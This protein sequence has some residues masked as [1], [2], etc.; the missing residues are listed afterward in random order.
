MTK[1]KSH[2]YRGSRTCGGGTHKNRRGGGSRGGRG[3]AGACKHNTMRA[4]QEGWMFGK[5]GFHRPLAVR[6]Y[7]TS[8]NVGE[9]DELSPYL[10]EAG[11][12]T[13]ENGAVTIDLGK[14]GFDKL[15]GNGRVSKKYTISVG[16]AS[17]SAKAK[18][19]EL[20]GQIISKT[21]TT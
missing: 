4:M 19:E 15:L 7:V 21:E 16:T 12:A 3:H 6:T 8:L 14:L 2:S 17:A 11:T 10:L 1:Q 18:V 9:L 5:H 13:E 20:G